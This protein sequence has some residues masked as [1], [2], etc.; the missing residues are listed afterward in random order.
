MFLQILTN[1]IDVLRTFEEQDFPE[2]RITTEIK[3]SQTVRIQIA[4]NG[5]GMSE[6]TRERIFEPFFTTK[7]I[8]QGTGLGLSMSYQIITEQ[9]S[10]TITCNS[11]WGEGTLFTI[12]LPLT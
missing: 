6:N 8:G 7:L 12:T 9:H 4:D 10:G 3:D 2:I 11:R 1:A 5:S